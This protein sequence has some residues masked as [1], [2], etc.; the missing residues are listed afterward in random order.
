MSV[1]KELSKAIDKVKNIAE[2]T[3]Q[4]STHNTPQV[5]VECLFMN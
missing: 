1:S 5:F 4:H 2:S 3:S